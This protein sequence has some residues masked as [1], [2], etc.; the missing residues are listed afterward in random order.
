MA[1]DFGWQVTWLTVELL[2]WQDL[3][4][5]A[6]DFVLSTMRECGQADRRVKNGRGGEHLIDELGCCA[7]ASIPLMEEACSKF[8][9]MV[10]LLVFLD[11]SRVVA[12]VLRQL[13]WCS[14]CVK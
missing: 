1:V 13:T 12:A 8:V 5:L 14:R 6:F 9:C 2:E 10:N 3:V 11:F 7:E 4:V